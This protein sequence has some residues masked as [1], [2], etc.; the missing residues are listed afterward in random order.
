MTFIRC[1]AKPALTG[2]HTVNGKAGKSGFGF[3]LIEL[4]VV[5]AIIATLLAIAVPRYFHSVEKSKEAVL[6]QDLF[7]L[8][9]AIDKYYG[10]N[11]KYPSSLD[12]LVARKYL[13]SIPVD[14]VTDTAATWQP[15]PPPDAEKGNVFDVKSGAP[16]N[17]LD[18]K[19]Y[20]EW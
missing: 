5:M 9:E 2:C 1:P 6:R 8:R 17:G 19:A 10:D 13:R 15:M 12:D 7:Q 14:P 11:G 16:G 3:T 20:S 4:L 18:G